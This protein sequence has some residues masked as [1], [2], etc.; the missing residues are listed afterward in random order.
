MYSCQNPAESSQFQLFQW[1]RI[2]AVLPAKIVNSIPAES[3]PKSPF[4]QNGHRND[5]AG[6]ATGIDWNGIQ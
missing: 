1:N 3:R 6:M 4:R 5:E 2:L